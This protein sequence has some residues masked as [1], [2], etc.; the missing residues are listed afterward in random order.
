MLLPGARFVPI[1]GQP[2]HAA[3]QARRGRSYDALVLAAA[4]L[5]RLGFGRP[6]LA[7]LPAAVCVPAPGR[8]S[9]PSRSAKHDDVSRARRSDA[10]D[11]AAGAAAL[12]AE[13]AVVEALGGGCQTPIGALATAR[14]ARATSSSWP[15]RHLAR[16]QR[17]SCGRRH[18]D[19][20]PRAAALGARVGAQ[21]LA[22]GAADILAE[23]RRLR[24]GC[25]I[26][27]AFDRTVSCPRASSI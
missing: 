13:R 18:A 4:G 5:R 8:A 2:R 14:R 11:D 22:D 12:A 10:I 15:H 23:A 25:T 24:N 9:S 6:H 17:A 7:G 26:E 27:A 21:L 1:R 16:R 20:R 19:R 3:A